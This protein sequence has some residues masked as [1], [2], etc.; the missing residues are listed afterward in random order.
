VNFTP[1]A[2]EFKVNPSRLGFG[3]AKPG[4]LCHPQVN[5]TQPDRP[6]LGT[7]EIGRFIAAS[8]VVAAHVPWLMQRFSAN[9]HDLLFGGWLP[10]GP[11]A[12]QYFFLLSGFVMLVAHHKDFGQP[13][14]PLRFWWRRA[15]RIY[16]MYWLALALL[17]FYYYPLAKPI[18]WMQLVA[19]LP[20]N[21]TEW[22]GPAWSLRYEIAFYIMFGLCLLPRVGK[23]IMVA[24][25]VVVFWVCRPHFLTAPLD[26]SLPHAM[27]HFIYA[28]A[29]RF[30]SGEEILFFAGL[31]CGWLYLEYPLRHRAAWAL[32]CCGV[33]WIIGCMPLLHWGY[34]YAE[35]PWELV[36]ATGYG[37]VILALANLERCG[38]LRTG[39]WALLMGQ[40]S[41]PLYILHMTFVTLLL[42]WFYGR[43]HLGL[44]EQ[45]VGMIAETLLIY[46]LCI[47]AALLVDQPLQ[48]WPRGRRKNPQAASQGLAAPP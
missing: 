21:F 27:K 18:T 26:P 9:P 35:G 12:V 46:A 25:M 39:R 10:P 42:I 7:L 8:M 45:Y 41:Y 47:A 13:G 2:A 36:I 22:V 29:G 30:F 17:T 1:R 48:S 34:D 28:T 19:L 4:M 37:S 40:I 6:K 14:A 16:P 43:L 31:L 23:P 3:F 38:A 32:L 24:W 33:V 5:V 44:V 11:V 20:G 15:C